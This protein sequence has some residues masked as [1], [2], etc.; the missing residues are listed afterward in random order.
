MAK[1]KSHYQEL[2]TKFIEDVTKIAKLEDTNILTLIEN[3]N[4]NTDISYKQC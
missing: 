2:D 1:D 3:I 4:Q